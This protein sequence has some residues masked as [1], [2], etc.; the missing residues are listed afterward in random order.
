MHY[1]MLVPRKV[2]KTCAPSSIFQEQKSPT[3]PFRVPGAPL[4]TPR[5]H[6]SHSP[7]MEH[8][9]QF[10]LHLGKCFGPKSKA[11]RQPRHRLARGEE[12]LDDSTEPQ[13][14]PGTRFRKQF[15]GCTPHVVHTANLR[16]AFHFPLVC[17][18]GQVGLREV[19]R[20]SHDSQ[21]DAARATLNPQFGGWGT[22]ALREEKV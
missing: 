14:F 19:D 6:C 12:E 3:S 11:Q 16:A 15:P 21:F 5:D 17:R 13:N 7:R 9:S 10:S 18:R 20:Q 22:C 4:I 1:M 2:P 8:F